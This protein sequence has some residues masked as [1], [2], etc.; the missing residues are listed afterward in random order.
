ML[1]EDNKILEFIQRHK[2][3]KT[4]FTIYVD[5][6]CLLEKIDGRKNNPESHFQQK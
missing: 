4:P 6:E 1:S 2:S 5:L 3:D